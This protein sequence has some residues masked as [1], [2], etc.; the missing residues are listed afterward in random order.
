[1]TTEYLDYFRQ[2]AAHGQ[3]AGL[4]ALGQKSGLPALVWT[5]VTPVAEDDAP[6][7]PQAPV[8]LP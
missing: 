1:M 4:L 3:L 6:P 8:R 5:I 7:R 2:N